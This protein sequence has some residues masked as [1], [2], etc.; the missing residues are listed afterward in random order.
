MSMTQKPDRSTTFPRSFLQPEGR[1]QSAT[2]ASKTSETT[3][4]G[5]QNVSNST[6]QFT[7]QNTFNSEFQYSSID[8]SRRYLAYSSTQNQFGAFQEHLE[9]ESAAFELQ[10]TGGNVDLRQA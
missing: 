3:D 5:L 9:N 1:L 8:F 6:T 2:F 7:R 4:P 10:T